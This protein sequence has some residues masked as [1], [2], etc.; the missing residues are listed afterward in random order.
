MTVNIIVCHRVFP[1]TSS[2]SLQKYLKISVKEARFVQFFALIILITKRL[3]LRYE[4]AAKSLKYFNRKNLF[5]G[6]PS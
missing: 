3:F 4:M 6:S 5:L 1:P 2:H